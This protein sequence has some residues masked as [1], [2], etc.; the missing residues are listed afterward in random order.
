MLKYPG[1]RLP[2][3]F[4]I[5]EVGERDGGRFLPQK[6]ALELMAKLVPEG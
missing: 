5:N 4:R 6:M 1:S 3:D 2:L